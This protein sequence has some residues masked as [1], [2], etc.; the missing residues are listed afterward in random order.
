MFIWYSIEYLVFELLYKRDCLLSIQFAIESWYMIDWDQVNFREELLMICMKQLDEWN[1]AEAL[2]AKN[3]CNSRKFNK[4]YFD[5][6][7]WLQNENIQLYIEDLILL[8]ISKS[9]F[10]RSQ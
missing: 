8:Y 10:S 7:K 5:E 2:A 4:I 1:L 3:L 9:H 6:Y